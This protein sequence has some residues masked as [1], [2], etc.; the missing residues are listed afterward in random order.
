MDVTSLPGGH[1]AIAPP[2]SI[3]LGP[4]YRL[5]ILTDGLL[6]YEWSE[7]GKFEDRASTFAVNRNLPTPKYELI[8]REDRMEVITDRYQ[9]EYDRKVFS[10]GGFK[11]VLREDCES[12]AVRDGDGADGGS[13]YL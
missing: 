2:S 5:T 12:S 9:L 8:E 4:N 7:D 11:V 13:R 6:R 10:P 1:Q 3:I